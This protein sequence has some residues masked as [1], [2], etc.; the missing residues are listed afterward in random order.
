MSG[1]EYVDAG[2]VDLDVEEFYVDG[3]RLTEE[4]AEQVAAETLAAHAP[5]RGRGR[6]S[7]TGGSRHS[8]VV[9]ARVPEAVKVA[10]RERAEREHVR[11]SQLVRQA[12]EEFLAR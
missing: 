11:E 3:R 5:L 1:Q 7:L 6:P 8:P 10:L 12:V 9:N 4:Q 2:D